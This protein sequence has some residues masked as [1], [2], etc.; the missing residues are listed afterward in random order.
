MCEELFKCRIISK[1]NAKTEFTSIH[2]FIVVELFYV[3]YVD[4]YAYPV[5]NH[6]ELFILLSIC[7]YFQCL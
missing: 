2:F 5:P 4:A 1:E 6:G 3:Q 7:L